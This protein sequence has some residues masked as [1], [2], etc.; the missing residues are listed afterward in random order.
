MAKKKTE[1]EQALSDFRKTQKEQ[2]NIVSNYERIIRRKERD[3]RELNNQLESLKAEYE[4]KC[5]EI[6]GTNMDSYLQ[7][8]R[9]EQHVAWWM[10]KYFPQYSF[11]IWQSDKYYKPYEEEEPIRAEWNSF[12]DLIFV[13]M[14]AQKAIAIECKFRNNGLLT[15]DHEHYMN[16]KRA[17]TQISEYLGVDTEVFVMAGTNEY[18][19]DSQKP[20]YMYCFPVDFFKDGA[21]KDI[22][23]FKEYLVMDRYVH[24]TKPIL[25]NIH[26]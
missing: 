5:Q 10:R 2:R 17:E 11:L 18:G 24:A 13:D 15:I 25:D 1:L 3:I 16:Y 4:A 20:E 19:R 12:P 23:L 7:G 14:K 6:F 21:E 8:V 9:F 22:K 26:F